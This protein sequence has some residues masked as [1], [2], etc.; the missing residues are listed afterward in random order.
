MPNAPGPAAY[1]VVFSACI[2]YLLYLPFFVIAV[3]PIELGNADEDDA[4][5]LYIPLAQ[6]GDSVEG[7]DF[8]AMIL[9][10]TAL[11]PNTLP[12]CRNR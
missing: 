10:D 6:E 2:R 1:S 5:N 12:T 9:H 7:L 4:G 11:S 8:L 3:L